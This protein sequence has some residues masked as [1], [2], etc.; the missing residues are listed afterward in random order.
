MSLIG[1]GKSDD[2]EAP[3]AKLPAKTENIATDGDLMLLVGEGPVAKLCVSWAALKAA[4]PVFAA[5]LGPHFQE[6]QELGCFDKPKE[7]ALPD[8]DALAMFDMC[9]L[10]HLKTPEALCNEPKAVRISSLAVVVDKY[11]RLAA[12]RL[13]TQ[14]LLLGWTAHY[15]GQ[16]DVSIL[17]T[18]A[19]SAYLLQSKKSFAHLTSRLIKETSATYSTLLHHPKISCFPASALRKSHVAKGRLSVLCT[20]TEGNVVA[21]EEKRTAA[22]RKIASGLLDLGTPVCPASGHCT[23]TTDPSFIKTVAASLGNTKYWP[24]QFVGENSIA[25]VLGHIKA[26]GT[27]QLNPGCVH[28]YSK[29]SVAASRF[30]GFAEEVER[31]CEGLCLS[32][33]QEDKPGLHKQCTIKEHA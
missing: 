1:T 33:V 14:A 25:K 22:Q 3:K 16:T 23:N 32:C 6:G 13:Q 19:A 20:R 15:V 10:L 21:L 30:V 12:L 17:G 9:S 27:M 7:V 26:L 2:A 18:M 8:D 31:M 28:G 11:A 29:I 4:S 24:P 5:M